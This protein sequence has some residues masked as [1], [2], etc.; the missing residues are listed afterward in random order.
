MIAC[1]SSWL[2]FM[3]AVRF[4]NDDNWLARALNLA[5]RLSFVAKSKG[6]FYFGEEKNSAYETRE[7]HEKKQK[8]FS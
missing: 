8:T 3:N 6:G 1:V 4:N 5:F 7:K 2:D